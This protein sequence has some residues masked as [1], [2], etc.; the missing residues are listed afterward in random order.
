MRDLAFALDY[1]D[2]TAEVALD[3]EAAMADWNGRET[4]VQAVSVS[5]LGAYVAYAMDGVPLEQKE[6]GRISPEVAAS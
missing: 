2:Q 5:P 1:E 4:T 6:S 3:P